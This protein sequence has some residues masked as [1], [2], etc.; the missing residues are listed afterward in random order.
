MDIQRN[1]S[2][3]MQP[4]EK[5]VIDA[6]ELQVIQN[7][8]SGLL[9]GN[10]KKIEAFKTKILK[11]SLS[12][13]LKSCSPA[14]IIQCGIQALTL[15]L[16]LEAGQGYVVKYGG[17]AQFDCGYKGWQVL[18][19]RAGFSVLADVVYKC[20]EFSQSGFGF[21]REMRFMPDFETRNSSNDKWARENLIGVIVSIMEDKTK[22]K[23]TAFVP[24]DMIHKIV[25]KSPSVQ[26]EKG[27]AFSPHE[28][29]AEQMF[30]A[31]AIKQVLSKFPIDLSEA[32]Q[33]HQAI[34]IV[35]STESKSQSNSLP[36]YPDKNF[37]LYFSKWKDSVVDGRKKASVIISQISTMYKLSPDQLDQLISLKDFEPIEAEIDEV[38]TSC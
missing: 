12:Y 4:R 28:N 5:S 38:A 35:N 9:D 33:L 10:P 18:A 11:M 25:G 34:E 26:S 7:Q 32:A 14:S 15:N 16:P 17:E 30:A 29:W 13:G 19:K 27:K 31:K 20:D 8:L 22:N 1:L 3:Q 2:V 23:T 36:E 24:A 21:D 37:Q 6:F